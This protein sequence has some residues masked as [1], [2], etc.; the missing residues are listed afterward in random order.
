MKELM[1]PKQVA[2]ALGVS[3]ASLKRWCDKGLIPAIRT[4]GGHRRLPINGV[5]HFIRQTGQ[6]LVRPE[7]LG[8]PPVSRQSDAA[9]DSLK[10]LFRDALESGSEEQ[11]RQI[12]MN[13]F[14]SG[15]KAHEIC[16]SVIAPAF[17]EIG[18]RWQHGEIEVYQERRGVEIVARLLHELRLILPPPPEGALTAIGATLEG[19]PYALATSMVEVTLL[20]AGWAARSYGCGHPAATLAAAIEDVRP[21]LFWLS[22][23]IIPNVPFFV[24]QCRLLYQTALSC[25]SA[26]VVGGRALVPE[27]RCQVGY[28]A[29]CDT[30]G[31]LWGLAMALRPS[32]GG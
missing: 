31:H 17:H 7:V 18:D 5:M 19:D 32:G 24:E 29:F 26:F 14:I 2:L 16:D 4:A 20:E 15:R 11:A 12:V 28:S 3:E 6:R 30:L 9:K 21:S 23:S 8:L 22:A 25:G 10:A 13:M 27:V 1:S